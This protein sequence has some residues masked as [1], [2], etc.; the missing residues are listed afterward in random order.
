MEQNFI[1]I[2]CRLAKIQ[3]AVEENKCHCVA[4]GVDPEP[5]ITEETDVFEK[6]PLATFEGVEEVEKCLKSTTY[7]SKLVC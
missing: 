6:F 2:K 4:K 7:K 3:Q 1:S 5:P